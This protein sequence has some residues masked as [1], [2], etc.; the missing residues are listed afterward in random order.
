MYHVPFH[1]CASETHTPCPYA[2]YALVPLFTCYISNFPSLNCV[3]K[4]HTNHTVSVQYQ[5][6]KC[7]V[8][9]AKLTGR[10]P[11]HPRLAAYQKAGRDWSNAGSIKVPL[12]LLL[13]T[14]GKT[15][16]RFAED[17]G[18]GGSFFFHFPLQTIVGLSGTFVCFFVVITGGLVIHGWTLLLVLPC[19][20]W[21]S[22]WFASLVCTPVV[23]LLV[24][25]LQVPNNKKLDRLLYFGQIDCLIPQVYWVGLI[26]SNRCTA[27]LPTF[28]IIWIGLRSPMPMYRG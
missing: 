2:L 21:R 6:S 23:Q 3:T 20:N 11:L 14:V 13:G 24:V 18:G 1:A 9:A 8:F 25:L 4:V 16:T 22:D 10:M 5:D 15:R 27:V 19:R 12:F 17:G 26:F 28:S 7:F